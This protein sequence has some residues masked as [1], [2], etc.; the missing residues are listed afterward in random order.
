MLE[1]DGD[2]MT[3]VIPSR[4]WD[5]VNRARR[6]YVIEGSVVYSDEAATFNTLSKLGYQHESMNRSQFE[7]VRGDVHT[8]NVEAF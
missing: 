5:H 1:R 6:D 7:W 4:R 8:N 2:V 3:R